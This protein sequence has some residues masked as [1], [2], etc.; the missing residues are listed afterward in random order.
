MSEN[1]TSDSDRIRKPAQLKRFSNKAQLL[2]YISETE[3]VDLDRL[4]KQYHRLLNADG[5][6][7]TQTDKND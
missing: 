2:R 7:P 4:W 3:G 1:E 6:S 5:Y